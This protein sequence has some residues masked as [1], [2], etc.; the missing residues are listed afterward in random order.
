MK[1]IV[2]ATPLCYPL[3]G[4]GQYVRGLL[5]ALSEAKPD[6][7]FTLM[8]PYEP[9]VKFS[10]ANII[11]NSNLA[12]ARIQRSAGWRAWWFDVELPLA[13]RHFDATCFWAAGGL[14][15]WA[16]GDID[17]ALTVY[18]FVPER[19]PETMSWFPRKYRRH[20]SQH[21]LPRVRWC[22]PISRATADE[23]MVMHGVHADAIVHPGIDPIFFNANDQM[24]ASNAVTNYLLVVGTL[25]PR[26]NLAVMAA[27]IEAMVKNGD[28][29][30]GLELHLVGGKGWQDGDLLESISRLE[31]AGIARRLG[32]VEREQ[33]PGLMRQARA[34]LMP[35][36]YEGFGMPVA[37]ALA[38]GCPVICSDIPP[39]REIHTGPSVFF[40]KLDRESMMRA[41]HYCLSNRSHLERP[42][43]SEAVGAFTWE[44]AA[45]RFVAVTSSEA[46]V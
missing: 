44:E 21:W 25:E 23:M 32:Y 24:S 30:T 2:D 18:D 4:I 6:W 29:P 5:Q 33:M 15:P 31:A 46:S 42:L 28:W 43:G 19:Y 38:A 45:R 9:L 34:L 39:F 10:A 20:N 8:A 36:I 41:Y 26:K 17:V 40:H 16:L 7:T 27:T 22:L 1:W 3:T 12:R 13:M 14:V 35:S 11:W 37:E